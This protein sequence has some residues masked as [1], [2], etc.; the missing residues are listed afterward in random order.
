MLTTRSLRTSRTVGVLALASAAL[1]SRISG[2]QA[3][4]YDSAFGTFPQS[5]GWV[6]HEDISPPTPYPASVDAEGLYLN[7][8][9]FGTNSP[10]GN[11]GGVWWSIT[12]LGIDFA[13]DFAL[14]ADVKILTA[15]DHT[16]N[17]E[18][19]WP[20]PGYAL[21]LTDV[22]GRSFWV[23]LGSGEIF[24]SNTFY[25]HYGESNTVTAPFVTTDQHH[26]YRLERAPGG[27]GAA[28]RIDGGLVLVLTEMGPYR[29]P[30]GSIS[31]IRRTGRIASR[32]RPGYGPASPR[33]M[34]PR[35][36]RPPTDL[37]G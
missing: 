10:P 16:I 11:G 31:A 7:T 9:G 36:A 2:A 21:S 13:Q 8:L 24:L 35:R 30:K 25:G 29:L 37:C 15:L 1:F 28:L 5:Q 6:L 23:G 26:V 19:G 20:R 22:N 27:V 4:L 12:Q 17:V 32:T 18:T 3:V 34:L 33:V 14:E